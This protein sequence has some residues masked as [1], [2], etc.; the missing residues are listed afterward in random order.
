MEQNSFKRGLLDGVPIALGYVAVSFG[1]GIIATSSGLPWTFAVLISFFNLTSAGQL[2][3]VPII[4][5]GGS[6]LELFIT[7]AI[8][9][10]RYALMSVSLTQC[11]GSSITLADR[12]ILAHAN[13]DEIFALA[14]RHEEIGKKYMYGVA[15]L[16]FLGWSTGTLLGAVA[17]NILPQ[18]FVSALSVSL[19]AMFVAIIVPSCKKSGRTLLCVL[20][21]MLMSLLFNYV[22]VLSKNVTSG[23]AVV[24][25][26]VVVSCV[27]ALLFPVSEGVADD[28]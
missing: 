1:F 9:N 15:V 20:S 14:V 7:Q 28:A 2:A 8:I 22:P 3:A 5:S 26:T 21:A 12:F 11:F 24:I 18:I 13:T 23:F 4:V 16:P 10:S 27:F 25:C 17:G 6:F 19:Y